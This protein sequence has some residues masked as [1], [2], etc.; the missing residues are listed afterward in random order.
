MKIQ[1]AN[2]HLFSK[3]LKNCILKY[4]RSASPCFSTGAYV[5]VCHGHFL[6]NS[7]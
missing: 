5:A 3:T 6:F 1:F 7:P 2:M 4:K